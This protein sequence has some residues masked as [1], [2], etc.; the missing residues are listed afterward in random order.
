MLW[1]SMTPRPSAP[2]VQPA[3][4]TWTKIVA[5]IGP[6]C[7]DRIGELIDAGMS[8]A[9]I[10]FSHG[11]AAGHRAR[12]ASVRR[13]ARER[14][15]AI[16]VLADLPGPKLR[17][18][19]FPGGQRTL[20]EGEVV[21][22]R[23]GHGVAGPG[24]VFFDFGGFLQAVRPDQRMVLADGLAVL[25]VTE[26]EDDAVVARVVRPGVL[27]DRKGVHMPD[28]ALD[29][30]LPT[31]RD[32]ECIE[33]ARELGVDMLGISFVG[34]ASEIEAVRALAPEPLLVAKIERR[35]ALEG[36]DAIMA[37]CDGV[38]VA[39]GDLGVEL[40]LE[41]V[42]M[43]QKTL[44]QA[45]PRAGRF[46]ITATEMLESMIGSSRPT[47]AEVADVANAVL[48]GSDA[49]MLSAETAV[50]RF[51]VEAVSTMRRVVAAVEHSRRYLELPKVAWRELEPDTA[52]AVAMAAVRVVE[53]LGLRRIVCFTES[54][55]TVRLL[56]RYRPQA[57]IVALSPNE[58][59]VQQSAVLAHVRPVLFQR[60]PSLEDMLSS[61]SEMLVA[62]GLAERDEE[63]VFV[64]GVPSG[65]PRSTNVVKVQRVGERVRLH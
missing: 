8:V 25:R 40:E 32:R 41:Q 43:V 45:A 20:L 50:G 65:V 16:G 56:S 23:Q 63:V 44:L 4:G 35:A 58:S 42:P 14:A 24:E 60:A 17:L 28:S 55:R 54:G 53:A 21:R 37:T 38:M 34:R 13:A 11:E 1:P 30:D 49:L 59:T 9:R 27:G 51:P 7:E 12:V 22:V 29:Y 6:A 31:A 2:D 3:E 47:R 10:N 5:T 57:E 62:R 64:A 18:G 46:T 33:L 36:L 15:V 26:V 52:N 48:D 19:R 39:R 61:A